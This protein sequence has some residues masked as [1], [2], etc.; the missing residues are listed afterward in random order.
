MVH[1]PCLVWEARAADA[2]V[3]RARVAVVGLGPDQAGEQRVELF[4]PVQALADDLVEAGAHAVELE[5]GH[6]LD[7]LVPFHQVASTFALSAS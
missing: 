5:S 7:E 3:D 4:A 1:L 2:V 6:G